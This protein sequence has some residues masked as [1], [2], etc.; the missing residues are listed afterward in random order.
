MPTIRQEI[1]LIVEPYMVSLMAHFVIF[2]LTMI[3]LV[4]MLAISWWVVSFCEK[5]LK[6]NP[7]A[8]KVL[9]GASDLLIIGHFALYLGHGL[10]L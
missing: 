9:V 5:T 6:V 7:F 8:V 2:C 10:S 1:W 4:L 3:A